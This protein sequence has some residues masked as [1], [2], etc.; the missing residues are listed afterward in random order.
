MDNFAASN[1][2]NSYGMPPSR[3]NQIGI[4][5]SPPPPK[6][7]IHTQSLL[8][9]GKK[10]LAS[11][12]PSI[13]LRDGKLWLV[14]GASG[15][16]LLFFTLKHWKRLFRRNANNYSCTSS[17]SQFVARRWYLYCYHKA[18]HAPSINSVW[19]GTP[20]PQIYLCLV[21]YLHCYPGILWKG[22]PSLCCR[23]LGWDWAPGNLDSSYM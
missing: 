23:W 11:M 19:R 8:D 6:A 15:I 10:P 18:A 4:Y 12:S 16:N 17:V 2:S 3:A 7:V 9:P 13:I 20:H 21:I 14:T 5:F 22:L 1:K